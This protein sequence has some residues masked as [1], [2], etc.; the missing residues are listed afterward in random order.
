M[1]MFVTEGSDPH[2]VQGLSHLLLVKPLVFNRGGPAPITPL[3]ETLEKYWYFVGNL[4]THAYLG[5]TPNGAKRT[6]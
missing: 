1:M 5:N 2:L 4:S 3:E 6:S